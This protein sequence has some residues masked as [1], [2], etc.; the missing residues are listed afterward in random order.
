VGEGNDQGNGQGN[1]Q[2]A[3]P[4]EPNLFKGTLETC[5]D[6][7]IPNARDAVYDGH[8]S[9]LDAITGPIADGGWVCTNADEWLGELGERCSDLLG[10]FDDAVTEVSTRISSEPDKVDENDW[11]GYAWSRAWS[12]EQRMR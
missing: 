10:P 9:P 12:M 1:G 8:G 7:T 5:R 4:K 6:T 2:Q 11:R 3:A